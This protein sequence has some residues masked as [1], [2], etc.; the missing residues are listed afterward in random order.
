MVTD[1]IQLDVT[2]GVATITM[3]RPEKLNALSPGIIRGIDLALDQIADRE[4]TRCVVVEGAGD[5][6]CAGGDIGGMDDEDQHGHERAADIAEGAKAVVGRLHGFELPTIARVD[7]FCFGAGVGVA[8]ANDVVFASEDAAFSLAFR[9]VGL[10]LDYGV[11]YFVREAVGPATAKEIA[12]TGEQISADRAD[13]IGLVNHTYPS[14]EFD[15]RVEEFVET[16]ASGPTVALEFS[17]RNIDRAG[18]RTLAEAIDAEAEAQVFAS[19][20]DD[21][22]EGVTAFQEDRDPAF[23]GR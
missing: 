15:E 21:H 16:V 11:S 1:D 22:T 10:T 7:G 9:N 3:D 18:D 17:L 23:E 2:D 6:F 8:L 5:A 14:D 12:L 13:E 19:E 20:T 4:D